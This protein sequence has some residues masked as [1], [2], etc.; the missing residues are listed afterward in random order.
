MRIRLSW[1]LL[2]AGVFF[3]VALALLGSSLPRLV[4][5]RRPPEG[6]VASAEAASLDAFFATNTAAALPTAVPTVTLAPTAS[7]TATL[8][9]T[10]TL[11][12]LPLTATA[13]PSPTATAVPEPTATQEPFVPPTRE[14]T[15]VPQA[16]RVVAVGF[17]QRENQVSYGFVVI[18]PN[19]E[20]L[21]RETRYLVAVYDEAGTVLRTDT[22]VIGLLGPGQQL[23][24]GKALS[25]AAD[26]RAARV[27]VQLREG[28]YA[29]ASGQVPQLPIVNPAFVPDETP[30]I[31]GIVQ[32]PL[33]GDLLDLP[34]VAIA[35]ENDQIVGGG[36]VVVPFIAAQGQTAVD[37]PIATSKTPTHVEIYPQLDLLPQ[38]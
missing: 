29:Q 4:G 5:A 1:Q 20:L 11:V 33:S 21:V 22:D 25:I 17:G 7:A 32:N 6:S 12:P 10:R 37:V 23:G 3:L 15:P 16:L 8:R 35:Y 27:E 14:P 9:P 38:T 13:S 26:T 24:R 31:T 18:N 2:L 30:R 28:L 34:V 19:G 36:S